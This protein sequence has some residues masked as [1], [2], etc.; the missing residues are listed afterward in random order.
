MSAGT[1]LWGNFRDLC[2]KVSQGKQLKGALPEVEEIRVGSES[3]MVGKGISKASSCTEGK[4]M[5]LF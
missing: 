1:E 3:L 4:G 5:F 2:A